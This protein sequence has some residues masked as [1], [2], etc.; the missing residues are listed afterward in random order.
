[1]KNLIKLMADN[2]LSDKY[3]I[4]SSTLGSLTVS[5]NSV[6]A[7]LAHEDVPDPLV[8]LDIKCYKWGKNH[9]NEKIVR[10]YIQGVHTSFLSVEGLNEAW[11]L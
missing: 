10:T 9:E 1:M 4:I 6:E 11:V 3:L 8:N 5:E 2:N 7:F